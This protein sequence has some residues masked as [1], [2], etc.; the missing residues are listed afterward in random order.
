[1]PYLETLHILPANAIFIDVWAI[2]FDAILS[3]VINVCP[4]LNDAILSM[5]EKVQNII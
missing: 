2:L 4:V 5:F 1:M 3:V